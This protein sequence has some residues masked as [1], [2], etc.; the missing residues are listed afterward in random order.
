MEPVAGEG[1]ALVFVAGS[2]PRGGTEHTFNQHLLLRPSV[3]RVVED[4]VGGGSA[5]T[6]RPK[7]AQLFGDVS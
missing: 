5:E 7:P 3:H 2:G 4:S 6:L 1:E